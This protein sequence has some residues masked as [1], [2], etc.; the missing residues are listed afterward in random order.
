[1]LNLVIGWAGVIIFSGLTAYDMQKLKAMRAARFSSADHEQK[2]AIF[3]ALTLYLDF[4][5]LVISLL[6]IFGGSRN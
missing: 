2:L 3:G 5:N 6:R 1:M 4:V